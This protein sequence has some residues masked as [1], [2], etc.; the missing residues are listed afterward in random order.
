MRA[1]PFLPLTRRRRLSAARDRARELLLR[2]F[3]GTRI[4][5]RRQ[6]PPNLLILAVDTLRWD[7]ARGGRA[8]PH[9]PR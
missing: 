5:P 4:A 6:G 9:H 3:R 2:P 7:H 1:D 8:A